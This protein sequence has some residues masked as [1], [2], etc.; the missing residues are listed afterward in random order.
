MTTDFPQW[1]A[2]TPA[3][4]KLQAQIDN[5]A[6]FRE[7]LTLSLMMANQKAWSNLDE[8]L[9]H[10]LDNVFGGGGQGWPTSAEEYLAYVEKYLVLIP[11]EEDDPEY[12]DAWTSDDSQNG[13]NQKVYDLLCQFYF[14]VDQPLPELGITMQE[15]K[16]GDFVFADWL[17]DFAVAL[18]A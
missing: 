5:D 18:T 7:A 13:Y 4:Q 3:Y 8:D 1:P 15:Y 10:A 2:T 11:N 6:A 16:N 14:L 9:Y 12:P 17:R